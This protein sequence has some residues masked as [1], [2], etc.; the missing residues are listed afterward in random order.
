ML[1]QNSSQCIGHTDFLNIFWFVERFLSLWSDE[2]V[3][4]IPLLSP[5]KHRFCWYVFDEPMME[6]IIRWAT[7]ISEL[8]FYAVLVRTTLGRTLRRLAMLTEF[9]GES[10]NLLGE[11]SRSH[12]FRELVANSLRNL[13]TCVWKNRMF[14]R[15]VEVLETWCGVI[16]IRADNEWFSR[17]LWFCFRT[18]PSLW[19]LTEF[20]VLFFCRVLLILSWHRRVDVQ[21]LK[22]SDSFTLFSHCIVW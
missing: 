22:K 13:S 16:S 20:C 15:F 12:S 2:N 5:L 9:D 14:S 4:G 17:I 18:F 6:R 21:T 8:T 19:L 1:W 10:V 3:H 11:F 7:D